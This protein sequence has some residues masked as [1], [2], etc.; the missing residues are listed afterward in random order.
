[1]FRVEVEIPNYHSLVA[2]GI[3]AAA[4]HADQS[5]CAECVLAAQ[6]NLEKAANNQ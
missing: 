2:D 4:A 6:T 5:A 3:F 1:M